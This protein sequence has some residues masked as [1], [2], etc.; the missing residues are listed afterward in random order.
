MAPNSERQSRDAG[1]ERTNADL[2]RSNRDNESS[3]TSLEVQHVPRGRVDL[4]TPC[5]AS[6]STTSSPQEAAVAPRT[7]NALP[8]ELRFKVKPSVW[9]DKD[10]E[11]LL[12]GFPSI[13]P[14]YQVALAQPAATREEIFEYYCTKNRW[15][16][17][18]VYA[19]PGMPWNEEAPC[20]PNFQIPPETFARF[21]E[22]DRAKLQGNIALTIRLGY[23]CGTADPQYLNGRQAYRFL[24][25]F[26]KYAW[27]EVCC[28]IDN[29]IDSVM[30]IMMELGPKYRGN[31]SAYLELLPDLLLVLSIIRGAQQV[32]FE[33]SVTKPALHAL[34]GSMAAELSRPGH[35]HNLTLGMHELG[36][37]Y[38]REKDPGNI[39]AWLEYIGRLHHSGLPML[40]PRREFGEPERNT[41][42]SNRVDIE[43]TAIK[44]RNEHLRYMEIPNSYNDD[45]AYF[46]ALG[47]STVTYVHYA[48]TLIDKQR[49]TLGDMSIWPGLNDDQR[50]ELHYQQGTN[51]LQTL[52]YIASP[53]NVN[54]VSGKRFV[55]NWAYNDLSSVVYLW[56]YYAA[57]AIE[58]F[59]LAYDVNPQSTLGQKAK[60]SYEGLEA[61]L[62][63]RWSFDPCNTNPWPDFVQVDTGGSTWRGDSKLWIKWGLRSGLDLAPFKTRDDTY[64]SSTQR[65]EQLRDE[66]GLP[67]NFQ[68][69]CLLR[70]LD[71]QTQH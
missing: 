59:R 62:R 36:E 42:L 58:R 57:A 34:A 14:P 53:Y 52:T 11:W 71:V 69:L 54:I 41:T 30:S 3:N 35:C 43:L 17:V 50:Q 37:H 51:H 18:L 61:R 48:W 44:M 13:E 5:Q 15:I 1:Q 16:E 38:L 45:N 31:D 27:F 6:S 2:E 66:F 63:R 39:T 47:A 70:F 46:Q 21:S 7:F 55:D 26:N 22:N 56:E 19:P 33:G 29:N 32:H 23:G 65:L 68:P 12:S 67:V 49:R 64:T 4:A 20:N 60:S 25:A 8:L 10:L 9:Y 24:F 40:R 28:D